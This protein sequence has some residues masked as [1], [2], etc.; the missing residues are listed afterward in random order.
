[1]KKIYLFLILITS[2]NN[3][4]CLNAIESLLPKP[5][6]A[7]IRSYISDSFS[8]NNKKIFLSPANP[9]LDDAHKLNFEIHKLGLDTLEYML[10]SDNDTSVSGL[11]LGVADNYLN[12]LLNNVNDARINVSTDFPGSEGYLI[13]VLPSQSLIIASDSIGLHYGILTFLSLIDSNKKISACRIIDKPEF[14]IRWFYYPMNILVGNNTTQAK[15]IWEQAAKLKLNGLKLADY[16]FNFINTMQKRYFDSLSSLKEFAHDRNLEIIPS[17]FSFGYSNGLLYWDPNLA[18]GLPVSY[19]KFIVEGDSGRL[20]PHLNVSLSNGGF[21]TSHSNQF[22]GF[23]FIDQ[24]GKLSSIDNNIK[25]SGSASLRF[26]NFAQYDPQNGHGRINCL[27]KVAPFTE[28]HLSGWVKTEN[29]SPAGVVYLKA[30]SK[31]G[32]T[33]NYAN[34]TVPSTTDWLKLDVTFNSLDNDSVYI[35]WGVWGA[36]G[37]KIWWDDL[38]FEEVSFINLIRRASAPVFVTHPILDIAYKEGVDFDSLYDPKMGM[39]SPWPGDYDSYHNPP[40]F[41]I[42]PGGIIH[43]RDTILISYY[44]TSVIYDDQVMITM[45]DPK[46]YDILDREFH[47]LD[48]VLKAKKYFMDHDEIRI[49][50]WDYGDLMRAMQPAEILA[51][52]VKKCIDIVHKYNPNADIWDW[53]D[54]FD[55]GHNAVDNYYFVNGGLRG[56]AD[57][58]PKSLGIVN[59][60]QNNL[61]QSLRFFSKKG[62]RQITAPF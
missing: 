53:S 38:L 6:Q 40:K 44:H 15:L 39:K 37:G 32:Q 43:N 22:P 2:S 26:E 28:Y 19:Q 61:W 54:M 48:S 49:M 20:V 29:L 58:L 31:G 16:K 51:D 27:T 57:S 25:H 14:P 1:M 55:E 62:F 33:L 11:V 12:K 30:I 24:P 50:N 13:D 59:W 4:F 36:K 34:V 45:S 5:R 42:K 41:K 9:A 18:S 47:V 35:Y 21:E 10:L 46:V 8:I 17:F 3:L 60:N 56:V 7:Y 52:N 23:T